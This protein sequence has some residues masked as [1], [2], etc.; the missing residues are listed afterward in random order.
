MRKYKV[1]VNR[2]TP[3]GYQRYTYSFHTYHFAYKRFYKI[4]KSGDNNIDAV[5]LQKWYK[6]DEDYH[7]IN[8]WYPGMRTHNL[9]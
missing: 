3:I 5:K 6:K 9:W 1:V 2:N 8:L 4:Y 7:T